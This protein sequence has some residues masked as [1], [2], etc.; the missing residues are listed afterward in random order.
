MGDNN[1]ALRIMNW[2]VG[3]LLFCV[4]VACVAV[5]IGYA[6]D[7][8]N[9]VVQGVYNATNNSKT[10]RLTELE[11]TDES[12]LCTAVAD[13]LAESSTADVLYVV[14]AD[15][16]GIS[17]VYAPTGLNVGV[18]GSA[19]LSYSNNP[20]GESVKHLLRLSEYKCKADY[21]KD[22]DENMYVYVVV[23]P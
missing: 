5:L 21:L 22:R 8:E 16:N 19:S 6:Q 7:R 12:V 1:E 10:V 14:I 2:I 9:A 15:P 3:L 11:L 4:V 17:Y 23:E 18:I 13:I 20:I